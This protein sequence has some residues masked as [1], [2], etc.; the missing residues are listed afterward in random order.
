MPAYEPK[1]DAYIEKAQP[2]AEPILKHNREIGH[3]ACPAVEEK[4]E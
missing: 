1:I 4:I 3:K 2:F